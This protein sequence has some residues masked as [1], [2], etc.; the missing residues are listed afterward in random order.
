MKVETFGVSWQLRNKGQNIASGT[1]SEKDFNYRVQALDIQYIFAQQNIRLRKG[2]KYTLITEVTKPSQTLAVFSP[3][4]LIRTW[5]S[6]KG[7]LLVRWKTR[8]TLLC[9]TLGSVLIMAGLLE[10]L[11][12]LRIGSSS[13]FLLAP[14]GKIEFL[15]RSD[16]L[17]G[18][19][20]D[21]V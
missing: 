12:S 13:I 6:L 9:L 17:S 15:K 7:Y 3:E 4:L 1:I 16:I 21:S 19:W 18:E 8:D 5:A 10:T 11:S 14:R 2:Q 20:L